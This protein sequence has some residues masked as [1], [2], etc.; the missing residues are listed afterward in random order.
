MDT[1]GL[2]TT[3]ADQR[4]RLHFTAHSLDFFGSRTTHLVPHLISLCLFVSRMWPHALYLSPIVSFASALAP[5]AV[6]MY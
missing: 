5:F 4:V 6:C 1:P 2:Q 3:L